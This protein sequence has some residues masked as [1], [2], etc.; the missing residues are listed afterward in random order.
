MLE[1]MKPKNNENDLASRFLYETN[2]RHGTLMFDTI[3][4]SGKNA[5]VLHYIENNQE[6]KDN[7]MV[8]L[9]LGSSVNGYGADISRTYP[10]NGSYTKR[11]KEVYN[12]V[13]D[14]FHTINKEAKPGVSLLDLNNRAKELLEKACRDLNL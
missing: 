7:E 10:I 9:D 8:L 1:E 2:K 5:T 11:Q 6:L 12:K 14:T 4:A 3:V 13:L